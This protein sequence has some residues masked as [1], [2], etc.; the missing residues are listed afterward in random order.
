MDKVRFVLCSIYKQFLIVEYRQRAGLGQVII[1][2]G[3][4]SKNS[5]YILL[6]YFQ[7]A[8]SER[9]RL[10]PRGDGRY[11][12][13]LYQCGISIHLLV[14]MDLQRGPLSVQ[15]LSELD[16]MADILGYRI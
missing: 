14:L 8:E 4:V 13:C 12:R 6:S 11:R 2:V 16:A 7:R 9:F 10:D 5:A 3:W 1:P 15:L